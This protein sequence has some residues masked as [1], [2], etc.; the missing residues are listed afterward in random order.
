MEEIASSSKPSKVT[1]SLGPRDDIAY[2]DVS[3][4][5][6]SKDAKGSSPGGEVVEINMSSKRSME[7][8]H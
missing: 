4:K 7:R 2:V 5:K 6:D 8:K 3:G 1:K